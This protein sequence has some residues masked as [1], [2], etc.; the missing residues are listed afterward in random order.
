MILFQWHTQSK[1]NDQWR[2]REFLNGGAV[3]GRGSGGCFEASPPPVRLGQS[4]DGGVHRFFMDPTSAI[5]HYYK[6]LTEIHNFYHKI[7]LI[8]PLCLTVYKP[9]VGIKEEPATNVNWY[10]PPSI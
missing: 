10:C 1:I 8:K 6:I 2:I 4:P 5:C 9:C 3:E 7:F